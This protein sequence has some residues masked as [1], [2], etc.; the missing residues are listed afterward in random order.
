MTT[1][2]P[3]LSHPKYRPDIDGLR[4]VAVLAVVAFH[5]FP[6]LVRGGFIGVDVFFVI[7]GYLI[8]TI[9]FENLDKGTFSF[10]EFYAR[11]IKRIFPALILVLIACFAFGWFALL[12]NEFKQ[13]GKHIAAG[14]GFVSN[15]VLWNEAGYFDSSAETKPLL[16][17]W[18]L[19][20]EEQF[21]IAWPLLL[22]LAWKC[23]FNLLTITL[24]VGITSFVLNI[25]GVKQD[26]VATFYSPQTR[27]WELLCGSFLAWF[28]LYK[29][30]TF[31][32]HKN[33]I[34]DFFAYFVY[35]DKKE[36]SGKVLANFVS[37][38]GLLLLMYGFL[39]IHKGLSFPGIWAL[40][41]ILGAVLII[42]AGA[43][44]WVNKI[45]L[46][47]KVAVW[48]GL[49]SFP[50]YLW[51][52]PLLSFARI[53]EDEIPSINIRIVAV[54]LSV[55]LAWLTYKLVE[56]PIRMDGYNKIKVAVPVLLIAIIGYAGYNTYERTDSFSQSKQL[57]ELDD[58]FSNPLPPV[59]DFD[60]GNKAP[61]LSGLKFDGGCKLSKNEEPT[62]LF[63]GDSHTAH[64]RNAVWNAFP[65]DSV[66]MVVETACLPFS[67]DKFLKGTCKEK[68]SAVI[69]YL[70][71]NKSIKTVVLSGH[72]AY[73]ISGEFGQK[74]S[75]W[76][77]PKVPTREN[78]DSFK[79]NASEFISRTLATGKSVFLFK[80]IPDLNFN[81][82]R[83]FDYRKF[84]I[85]S[86]NLI[87]DC[88]IDENEF[89][90]RVIL[91]DDVIEE[92][93]KKFP[94]VKTFNPRQYFCKEG[95]CFA[96]DGSLPYYFNGDHV[97]HHGAKIIIE[98]YIDQLSKSD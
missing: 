41:P 39:R 73:L 15:L 19:G 58:I 79:L 38:V 55:L 36:S 60:C 69:A 72:W 56:Q 47:N 64:Y 2:T 34:C 78:I 1:P 93:L 7:S 85:T 20:I 49:I 77:L 37:F 18:S 27:F 10:S 92:V 62:I 28:T 66:L 17:L 67:S 82:R 4:A 5:A 57:N 44:A 94:S 48:F 33:M 84:R 53:V 14:A 68:Y 80:D 6:K 88:W 54:V 81:I 13:L 75:N 32:N 50:L 40:V 30:G 51:H 96:S 8:S 29:N 90:N 35:I 45:I 63:L 74:G 22:W 89:M 43:K 83:C 9:I 59:Y 25:K 52:W 71:R 26:S 95:K 70:E 86:S 97:N 46:S 3:H 98:G 16:H 21:Y 11:R 31:A 24:L 76:R 91:Y 42:T 12:A 61:E 87:K 23:K 65:K